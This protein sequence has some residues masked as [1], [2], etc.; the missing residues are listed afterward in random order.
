MEAERLF[1]SPLTDL[2]AQG[3]AGMFSPAEVIHIQQVLDEV[4]QRAVA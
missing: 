3:P 1:E 4:R 2:N